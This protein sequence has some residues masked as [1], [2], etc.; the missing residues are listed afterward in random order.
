M[1]QFHTFIHNFRVIW[2]FYETKSHIQSFVSGIF[3]GTCVMDLLPDAKEK[4]A[5]G[6]Y[7]LGM[8]NSDFPLAEFMICAGFLLILISEQVSAH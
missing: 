6:L 8:K 1:R 4:T 3:L 7:R 2:Q 5:T